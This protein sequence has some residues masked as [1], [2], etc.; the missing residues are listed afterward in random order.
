MKFIASVAKFHT[1]DDR[2]VEYGTISVEETGKTP[3]IPLSAAI[4]ENGINM[5]MDNSH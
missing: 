1:L 5:Q 4:A 3:F 2:S